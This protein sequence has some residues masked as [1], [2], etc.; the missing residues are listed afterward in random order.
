VYIVPTQTLKDDPKTTECVIRALMKAN[1]AMYDPANRQKVIDLAVKEG[2]IDPAIAG[3]TFDLLVK[4]K[5]WPQNEGLLKANIEGTI[6]SE[7][8]FKKI[9]KPLTFEDVTDLTIVK[10]VV[11]QLGRVK[12]FPY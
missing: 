9:T 2:K 12:D 8:D 5:A 4:A 1:R 6:K 11:E 3:E 7:T 10:R